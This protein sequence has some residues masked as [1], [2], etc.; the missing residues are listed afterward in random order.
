M[1]DFFVPGEPAP[2]GSKTAMPI[3]K[4]VCKCG[5]PQYLH[6]GKRL[7]LNYL[8]DG[9]S[10]KD[11][12]TGKTKIG[13]GNREWR[14]AV[15]LGAKRRYCAAP[16]EGPLRVLFRF[17]VRRPQGQHV[18]ND[19]SRPVR[20]DYQSLVG[21]IVA[22]DLTKFI[23]STEDALTDAGMWKDD[24]QVVQQYAEKV[25]AASHEPEGC[26]IMVTRCVQ[27][28]APAALFTEP[29]A[30][31][32]ARY[33]MALRLVAAKGGIIAADIARRALAGEVL[34]ATG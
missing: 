6:D 3:R 1:I 33:E 26:R 25:Y 28:H 11:P 24:S 30:D 21:P 18:A 19:R 2:G 9:G 10:R 16:L 17:M 14:A 34:G 32:A 7:I 20:E 22:P 27:D 12:I 8:D 23:R 4:G 5:Q 15:E 13:I 31:Q 29:A